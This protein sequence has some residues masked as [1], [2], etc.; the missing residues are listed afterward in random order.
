MGGEK[1]KRAGEKVDGAVFNF[2][3]KMGIAG[4]NDLNNGKCQERV[5]G[6][7]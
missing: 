1:A 2:K 5:L 7:D 6:I 3:R 4:L